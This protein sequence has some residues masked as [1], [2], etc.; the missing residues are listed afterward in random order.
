MAGGK[1]NIKPEDNPKPFQKGNKASPGHPKGQQNTKTIL[2]KIF[3]IVQDKTNP[4]TNEKESLSVHEQ[5]LITQTIKALKGDTVALE[6]LL[7][8]M[9]GK[10]STPIDLKTDAPVATAPIIQV[11]KGDAPPMAKN[12]NDLDV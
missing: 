5:L 1:G 2:N 6:R 7:D 12:E 8:R 11:I 3:S 10:V 9:E 4:F